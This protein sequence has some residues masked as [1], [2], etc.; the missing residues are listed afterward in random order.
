MRIESCDKYFTKHI[1][2][3]QY[4]QYEKDD[5]EKALNTAA[6]DLA[7]CGA[8][9][10]K[11]ESPELLKSA[12]CEQTLFVLS[13]KD[14]YTGNERE[15]ISES[16]DG[17]GSCHYTSSGCPAH[18]SVKAYALVDAYYRVKSYYLSRG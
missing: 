18:I 6:T 10:I 9:C 12:L 3:E 13:R 8:V 1:A 5:R 17:V 14:S 7:S 4:F 11:E 16:I 15:V 2:G